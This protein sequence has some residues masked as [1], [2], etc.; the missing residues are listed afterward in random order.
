MFWW[1]FLFFF[2][3]FAEGFDGIVRERRQSAFS[4]SRK[5]SG[6]DESQKYEART[7]RQ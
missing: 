1:E 4:I 7:D 3:K 6:V 2:A 5:G